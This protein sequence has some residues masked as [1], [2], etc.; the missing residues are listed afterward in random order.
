MLACLIIEVVFGTERGGEREKGR[1]G[2]REKT[3]LLR[4]KMK[5]LI[6]EAI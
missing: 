6:E 4:K 3:E 2:E 1:K 5:L